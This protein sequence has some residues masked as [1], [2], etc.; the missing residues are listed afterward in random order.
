M[1]FGEIYTYN[2]SKAM[3]ERN[4]IPA[5]DLCKTLDSEPGIEFSRLEES[6]NP[7]D[8]SL[9]HRH[10]YYEILLFRGAGGIHEIDFDVYLIQEN[11]LHFIS[12]E[13]VH[14]LR[15]DKQVTGYV[16]SFTPDFF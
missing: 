11:S 6:Y 2:D 9:P 1:V 14:V 15:R 4:I 10:N 12:P 3:L 5:F 7:Y 13:R 16:L 8:A